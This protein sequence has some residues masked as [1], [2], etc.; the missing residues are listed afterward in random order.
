MAVDLPK[1]DAP[2]RPKVTQR[3]DGSYL[4]DASVPFPDVM[5]LT[6]I[7]AA[8][9]GDY[10]TLAGF[11]LAQLHE[12][13]KPGDHVVWARWRFE[14]VDMD[15]WRIDTILAQPQPERARPSLFFIG[16][17]SR[18]NWVV[19]DQEHLRGGLFVDRAVALRFAL[20]ENGNR[21]QAVVMVPGVLELD[22]SGK[23]RLTGHFPA[24]SDL[25]ERRAA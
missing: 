9:S 17:D 8:P 16:R 24:N 21:P 20:F 11:I 13:P 6:G 2:A 1:I 25:A 14:V 7:G 19:Q 22:L 10:V 23:A 4:I 15:G 5:Q 3:E 18:G 12:L